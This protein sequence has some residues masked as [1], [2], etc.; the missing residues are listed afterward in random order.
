MEQKV[1]PFLLCT[2]KRGKG[3]K[4]ISHICKQ[5]SH[6]DH[7][8]L[9]LKSLQTWDK[10]KHDF[11]YNKVKHMDWVDLNNFGVSH[12]GLP[13]NLFPLSNI[14]FDTFH[15]RSAIT[16]HLLISLRNF[17]NSQTYDCQQNFESILLKCW[18]KYYVFI[19]SANK[20]LSSLKGKD[21]LSFIRMIPQV[22]T[23]IQ[24]TFMNTSFL[25]N[26]CNGLSLWVDISFFLHKTLILESENQENCEQQLQYEKS[27]IEFKKMYNYFTTMVLSHF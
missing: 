6:E 25:T 11:G 14:R 22:V 16:R 20:P 5:I 2:C 7:N 21:I 8:K 23:F 19:W 10:H 27:I 17:I 9:Y 24:E 26:L 15:L 18:S 1:Q 3:V 13:P 12:F 4:D